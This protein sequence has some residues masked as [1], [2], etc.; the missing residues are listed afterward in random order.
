MERKGFS[1]HIEIKSQDEGIVSGYIASFN[2]LDSDGDIFAPNAFNK[3][4]TERGPKGTKQI[5]YLLDHDQKKAIGVFTE[6]KADDSGL[7]YEAKIGSH[8]LGRDY[9]EMCKSGIISEHSVGFK[10][11]NRSSTDKRII[12]EAKLYEGSGLQFLGANSNTPL[13]SVKSASD[14]SVD[15]LEY[16]LFKLSK[17]KDEIFIKLIKEFL[18]SVETT[19][20]EPITS[21][22]YNP[23]RTEII[24]F[25]TKNILI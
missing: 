13:L 24:N 3:S 4:L 9:L 18:Q 19:E 20:A 16:I 23:T 15:D 22:A 17:T 1:S 25:Y 2:T 10:T 12:T 7:Y 8:A 14:F 21:K 11:I 5:K 6:L